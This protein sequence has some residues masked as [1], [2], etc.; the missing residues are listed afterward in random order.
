MGKA[1][2]SVAVITGASQGIGAGLV[3]GYR[4]RGWSVVANARTMKSSSDPEVLV[5]DREISDPDTAD[6]I[7]AQARDRFCPMD[8]RVNNADIFISKPCTDYTP[9]GYDRVV[10][11]NLTGF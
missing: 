11:V 8:P 2:P 5:V 7:V 9:Q 10:G 1:E 4:D 6:R 3:D